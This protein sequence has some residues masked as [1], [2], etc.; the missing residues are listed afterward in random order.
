MGNSA[1]PLDALP[2]ELLS[3]ISVVTSIGPAAADATQCTEVFATLARLKGWAAAT[4]ARFTSRVRELNAVGQSLPPADLHARTPGCSTREAHEKERR[5]GVIDAAPGSGEALESGQIGT[6]HVDA[7]AN[8][9]AKLDESVRNELFDQA[10]DL[11][12]SASAIT[13]STETN[14]D[15]GRGSCPAASIPLQE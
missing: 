13:V 5:S 15:V 8:A 10:E 7:L 6:A 11:L 14:S 12:D 3:A 4:E 2:A 9:T 1:P